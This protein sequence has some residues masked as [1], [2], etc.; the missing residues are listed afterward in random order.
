MARPRVSFL[1]IDMSDPDE[2]RAARNALAP[3]QGTYRVTAEPTRETRSNRAN[4]Y[5]WGVVV[6]SFFEFLREQD[7]EIRDPGE[8]HEIIKAKLLPSREVRKPGTELVV[9]RLP[10]TTH[11]MDVSQFHD[12]VERA[13][14]WLLDKLGIDTPDPGAWRPTRKAQNVRVWT[15]P[16]KRLE[17]AGSTVL[18]RTS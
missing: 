13:R 15:V 11:D 17:A 14:A 4:R 10:P 7:Y 2:N 16:A 8:A 3:L 9:A 12:F 5:Y 6:A 1:W 18:V